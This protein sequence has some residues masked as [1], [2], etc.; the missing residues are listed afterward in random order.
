MNSQIRGISKKSL[1]IKAK[2]LG[3]KDP[4][5]LST[6]KLLNKVNRR[7]ISK[8]VTRLLRKKI[9]ERAILPKVRA[10]QKVVWSPH[11]TKLHK[12]IKI[13]EMIHELLQR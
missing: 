6:K 13:T 11:F 4:H 12:L 7:N 5:K 1:I 9:G 2:K 3:I 10:W 8:K